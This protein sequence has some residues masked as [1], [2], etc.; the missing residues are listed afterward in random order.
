[1]NLDT[2]AIVAAI[3]AQVIALADQMGIDA[4]DLGAD[5][6]IPATGYIDS[7]GLLELIA[8]FEKSYAFKIPADDLTIDHLGTPA[9]MAAYVRR[10]K[11]L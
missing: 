8:W 4:S 9:S 3:Q 1:M 10:A 11:G 6:L 5:D 2:D 7:A